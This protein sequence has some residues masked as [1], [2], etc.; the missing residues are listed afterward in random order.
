MHEWAGAWVNSLFRN[1]GAGLSSELIRDAIAVTRDVWPDTPQL[2]CITFVDADKIRKKRDPGRC[3]RRAGFEHVGFTKGG[4][5]TFQMLPA[6]MPDPVPALMGLE[7][8][9]GLT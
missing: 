9:G 6:S 2:G 5:Y 1:E 7:L 4:L 8:A 3:Y